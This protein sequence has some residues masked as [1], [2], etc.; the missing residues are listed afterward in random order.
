MH[1]QALHL[2]TGLEGY[3]WPAGLRLPPHSAAMCYLTHGKLSGVLRSS[4]FRL[5]DSGIFGGR[6][7]THGRQPAPE[8]SK[9]I[10]FLTTPDPL[11]GAG[12]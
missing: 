3:K 8:R 1:G 10:E 4:G 7:G 9:K 11:P 2:R 12:N 6:G 5:I